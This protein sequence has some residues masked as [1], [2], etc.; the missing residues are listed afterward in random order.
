MSENYTLLI[1]V[2]PSIVIISF[3]VLSDKFR[4]PPSLIF[5]VFFLG[6]LICFPA[7]YLNGLMYDMFYD[8][9]LMSEDLTS[10]FLGPA[11]TEE[12]LKFIIL[13]KFIAKD[14]H[15]NEP[16]DGIVYGV[17]ASLGFATYENYDYVFRLAD[18]Y[19]LA[20]IE[21]AEIR[22]W[23]A[24]PM[25]GLNGCIMGFFFGKFAFKGE[26]KYLAYS[27]IMPY[28]FH[29]A[30]NFLVPYGNYF[31]LVLIIML[32]LAYKLHEDLKISQKPKRK[33]TEKKT[34]FF[35]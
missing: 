20:R 8:G 27:L 25:H 6:I 26:R 21:M 14:K 4:E 3:F 33:E 34:S 11:W 29:G 1:T 12:L 5:K 10:S 13:Y 22:A 9:T 2:L 16:M 23:S 31:Y 35:S 32:V 30:Y 15:F 19:G 28:L 18:E 7:G 17:V 24:I